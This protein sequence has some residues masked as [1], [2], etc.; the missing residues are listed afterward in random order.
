LII[1]YSATTDQPTLCNLTNH[2]YYN[3]NGVQDNIFDHELKINAEF[4]TP[5]DS[6]LIPTGEFMNVDNT[7]FDFRTAKPIGHGINSEH[8][9]IQIAGG[10]DHNF[11]LKDSISDGLRFAAEV[12]DPNS[13]RG[14]TIYTTEPGLQFYSGNF[15]NGTI[16]GKNGQFYEKYYAFCLETQH[17]PDSPNKTEWP[18]TVLLPGEKYSSKTIHQFFT[19]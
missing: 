5:T 9:Q 18:S 8:L 16:K 1:E 14:M 12:Y 11:V 19:R 6:G 2:N 17:F 15:L 7:P 3:L 10:F 4:I 13:G